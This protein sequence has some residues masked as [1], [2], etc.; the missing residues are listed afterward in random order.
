MQQ[1]K[2][3]EQNERDSAVVEFLHAWDDTLSGCPMAA[4]GL[5]GLARFAGLV[6][7]GG[8]LSEDALYIDLVLSRIA[9]VWVDGYVVGR[10]RVDGS[11][12]TVWG[13]SYASRGAVSSASDR[14]QQVLEPDREEGPLIH[15]T[16]TFSGDRDTVAQV[17]N[18]LQ[19]NSVSW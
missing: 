11:G 2:N 6:R 14:L 9:G 12:A 15:M 10:V 17:L 18:L 4:G 7:D 3:T 5:I 19:P 1:A 16:L 8:Y 13:L